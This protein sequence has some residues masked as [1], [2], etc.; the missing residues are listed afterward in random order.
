MHRL[1]RGMTIRQRQQIRAEKFQL[2]LE[3]ARNRAWLYRRSPECVAAMA[4][5][6]ADPATARAQH[7]QCRDEL[8]GGPGCL[9]ECHDDRPTEI[10]SGVTPV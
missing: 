7:R 10:S 2:E 6:A 1:K 5:M 8:P 3:K 4:S 9:C